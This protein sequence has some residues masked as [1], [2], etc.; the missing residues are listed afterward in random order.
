[1]PNTSFHL[2]LLTA[3]EW[4]GIYGHREPFSKRMVTLP[5]TLHSAT[6]SCL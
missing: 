2:K 3:S 5:L 1:M 6:I 4:A